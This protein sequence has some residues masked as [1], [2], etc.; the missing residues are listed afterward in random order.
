MKD[1]LYEFPVVADAAAR[2]SS[3][4]SH[5]FSVPVIAGVAC[6]DAVQLH[7]TALVR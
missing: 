3:S 6:L 2:G 7:R 5:M 1:L 4:I